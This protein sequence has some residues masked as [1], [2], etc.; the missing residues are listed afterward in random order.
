MTR[1]VGWTWGVLESDSGCAGVE[2]GVRWDRTWG[3]LG[4]DLGCTGVGLGVHWG[5]TWDALIIGLDIG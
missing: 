5:Q 3:V 2:L 1:K 4:T